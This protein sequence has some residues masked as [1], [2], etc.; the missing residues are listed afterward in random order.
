MNNS[1]INNTYLKIMHIIQTGG[2]GI[3]NKI[4][5]IKKIANTNI[6]GTQTKVGKESAK[7]IYAE[8]ENKTKNWNPNKKS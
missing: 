4:R 7:K 2:T 1:N 5:I 3:D 6:S 8:Y